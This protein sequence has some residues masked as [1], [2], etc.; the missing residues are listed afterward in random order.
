MGHAVNGYFQL[1]E[2][3]PIED[4]KGRSEVAELSLHGMELLLLDKLDRF[5]PE[6][7]DFK[8][9]Q[10]EEL[11]RA[12]SMLIGPLA[13]DLFQHWMLQILNTLPKSEMKSTLKSQNF[14]A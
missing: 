8:N 13:G 11:R 6:E 14:M 12:F 1:S 3:G 2:H 9:A 10:R 7:E 5:Y 4:Y